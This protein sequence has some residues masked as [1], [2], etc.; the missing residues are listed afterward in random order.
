MFSHVGKL[1][2]LVAA[3]QGIPVY[4]LSLFKI[5]RYISK[6]LERIQRNFLWFGTKEKKKLALL[7]WDT[8]CLPKFSGGLDIIKI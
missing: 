5:P 8:I 2:L 1:Q 6:K 4:F 7:S 3:L